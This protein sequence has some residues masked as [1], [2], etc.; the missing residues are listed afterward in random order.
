MNQI[1]ISDFNYYDASLNTTTYLA[2]FALFNSSSTFHSQLLVNKDS[3][4]ARDASV[5][6]GNSKSSSNADSIL[7]DC[8][9]YGDLIYDGNIKFGSGT[10]AYGTTPTTFDLSANSATNGTGIVYNGNINIG[11]STQNNFYLKSKICNLNTSNFNVVSDAITINTNNFNASLKGQ[12]GGGITYDGKLNISSSNC[13]LEFTGG[14]LKTDAY[15]INIGNNNICT[16]NLRGN[17]NGGTGITYDGPINIGQNTG[18]NLNVSGNGT[19]NYNGLINVFSE[20]RIKPGGSIVVEASNNG[21]TF[22]QTEVKV[23]EQMNI[24]NEGT[25]PALTVNQSD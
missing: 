19:I 7:F 15:N 12:Y 10:S 13:N 3:A 21:F 1:T 4:L 20:L 11:N 17:A 9:G 25:G 2:G 16:F 23:T 14:T 6:F 22:L 18:S 24:S 5:K 8:F